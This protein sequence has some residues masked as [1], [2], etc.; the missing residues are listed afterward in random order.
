MALAKKELSIKNK[1]RKSDTRAMS[2]RTYCISSLEDKNV[3]IVYPR[4][5]ADSNGEEM[6]SSDLLAR[7]HLFSVGRGLLRATMINS[8]LYLNFYPQ[9]CL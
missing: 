1:K 9:V 6:H 7:L 5:A 3:M 4:Q 2:E 8:M